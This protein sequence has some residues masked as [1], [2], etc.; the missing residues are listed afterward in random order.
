[1]IKLIHFLSSLSMLLLDVTFS[2]FFATPARSY[3]GVRKHN[4][5]VHFG[6]EFPAGKQTER[7]E[8]ARE[9][10]EGD[11]DEDEEEEQEQ[12]TKV[13]NLFTKDEEESEEIEEKSAYQK[14]LERMKQEI[15]VLENE[16]LREKDWTLSGEVM[17]NHFVVFDVF[18]N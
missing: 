11:E 3:G 5:S 10:E 13:S 15:E 12:G 1:M 7:K 4:K 18:S 6:T 16:N 2:D 9:E 14:R 17:C 8:K